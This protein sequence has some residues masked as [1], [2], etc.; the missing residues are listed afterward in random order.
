MLPP[1][2]CSSAREPDLTTIAFRDGVMAA[3]SGSRYGDARHNWARKLAI[4]PDGTLYGVSG[5][6]AQATTFLRWVDGGCTGVQ[7][8]AEWTKDDH[9]SFVVLAVTPGGPVRLITARGEESYDAPYDAI[10]YDAGVA[11]GALFQGATAEQALA[12]AIE[13]GTGTS[14][15]VQ[16]I[17]HQRSPT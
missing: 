11:Y 12:A 8:V 5:D 3:D 15:K 4:G 17:R 7:P 13:H 14:G 9:S 10:G 16:T 2:N 1:R 6:A